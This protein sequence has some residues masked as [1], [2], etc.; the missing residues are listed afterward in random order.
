MAKEREPKPVR[1]HPAD[2]V[3]QLL[4]HMPEMRTRVNPALR[5]QL[6]VWLRAQARQWLSMSR[7]TLTGLKG[8]ERERR[9]AQIAYAK[10]CLSAVQQLIARVSE[11]VSRREVEDA[12]EEDD[13]LTLFGLSPT[14]PT[15]GN[16]RPGA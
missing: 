11:T 1:A 12:K 4:Q 8:T 15:N 7:M 9:R 6:R 16:P 10:N 14:L 2:G 13:R 5:S 3:P